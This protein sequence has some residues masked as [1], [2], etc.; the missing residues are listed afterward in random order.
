MSA[1]VTVAV[2]GLGSWGPNL[3]RTM[4]A[5]PGA[6]L[7][8]ICDGSP[9]RL[10]AA[11]GRF[12]DARATESIDELLE[13][14]DLQAVV[15]ATPVPTHAALAR[16]CLAAGKHVLV[17]K[18]LAQSTAEAEDAVSAAREHGRVLMVGPPP[19]RMSW[20]S[21]ASRAVSSASAGEVSMKWNVVPPSISIDGRG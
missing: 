12:T 21:A 16:R 3:A 8:W 5:M 9:E 15:I 7:S 13:D 14:D 6:R 17:E 11:R 2:A 1:E 4:D 19:M 10:E 18:P 20:P